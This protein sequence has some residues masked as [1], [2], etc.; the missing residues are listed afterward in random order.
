MSSTVLLSGYIKV[1]LFYS[2]FQGAT[3][4]YEYFR[5]SGYYDDEKYSDAK[6]LVP[7]LR[8]SGL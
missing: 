8:S 4:L 6:G 5:R 7:G 1:G 3:Y 2:W